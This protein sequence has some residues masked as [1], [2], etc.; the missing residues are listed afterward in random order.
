MVDRD[1]L[2]AALAGVAFGA[3]LICLWSIAIDDYVVALIDAARFPLLCVME[4][5]ASL[6]S[7]FA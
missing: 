2:A 3:T 6:T 5:S 4:P 7:D 1:A